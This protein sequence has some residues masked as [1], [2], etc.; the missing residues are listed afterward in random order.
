MTG[1]QPRGQRP[2]HRRRARLRSGQCPVGRGHPVRRCLP[3]H[4]DGP[5][6]A[7]PRQALRP[8]AQ[9]WGLE[10]SV[11]PP[12]GVAH[13]QRPASRSRVQPGCDQQPTPRRRRRRRPRRDLACR[14]GYAAD[15]TSARRLQR[16]VRTA[17]SPAHGPTVRH[18]ARPSR[19]TCQNPSAGGARPTARQR[20][21]ARQVRSGRT[22]AQGQATGQPDSGRT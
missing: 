11:N 18:R 6:A 12:E 19:T 3:R 2:R 7:M 14:H 8:D 15:A 17:R 22:H 21:C 5:T 16:H 13:R 20:G 4:P 10:C 1:T 9:R